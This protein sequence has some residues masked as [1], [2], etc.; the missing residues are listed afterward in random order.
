MRKIFLWISFVMCLGYS[1][2]F[3]TVQSHSAQPDTGSVKDPVNNNTCARAGCHST[4][5]AITASRATVT[6]G[7][8]SGNQVALAGFEYTPGTAYIMNFTVLGNSARPGFQMSALS[9][10]NANAGTFAVTNTTNTSLQTLNTIRYIGHKSANTNNTWSFNW[11]APATNVGNITFYTAVNKSNNSNG[12]SGDSIFH[13]QYVITPA[14]VALTVGAGNDVTV[15]P[16]TGTQ[17]QATASNTSGTT[18]AWSPATGLSCTTCANP[19]ATPATSTTYTVTVTNGGQTASDAVTVNTHTTNAPAITG[20]NTVCP[21]STVTLSSTGFSSYVWST[22][23]DTSSATVNAG[24]TYTLT[25][26]DANGC[27]TTASKTVAQGQAATTSISST[28]PYLCGNNSTVLSAGNF[29]AY[30]WSNNAA[31]ATITA[32]QAGNY[33]VTVTNASGCTGTAAFNLQAFALP[34]ANVSASGPLSFCNGGSVTLTANAG[35]AYTYKWSTGA[36]VQAIS[37]AQSGNYRVTVYNQCDSA[38][39]SIQNVVVNAVPAAQ[40]SPDG[41]LLLCNGASQTLFATPTGAAYVWLKDGAV[42]DGQAADTLPVGT[43]GNYAVIVT[44]GS[45]SDTSQTV[46]ISTAGTGN[47]A[48]EIMATQ[49][50]LCAGETVTLDAG[51]GFSTYTWLP[52]NSATQTLQVTT[53]GTYIVNVSNNNGQCTST[54]AD[55]ITIVT[56]PDVITPVLAYDSTICAGDTIT[57]Q[58]EPSSFSSYVWSNGAS[59]ATISDVTG[60]YSVTVSQV[61]YCGT[62][63]ATI[64][65]AGTALPDASFIINNKLL[66]ANTAGA[67]YQWYRDGSAIPNADGDSYLVNQTGDYSLQVTVNGCSNTSAAQQVI[68]TAI[69]DIEADILI[70]AYPNPVDGVLNILCHVQGNVQLHYSIAGLDGRN[71]GEGKVANLGS[72]VSTIQYDMSAMPQGVYVLQLQSGSFNKSIR[73]LKTQ[74]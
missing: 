38:V 66:T 46:S 52:G 33:T 30:Q 13:Q 68:V 20:A 50:T 21:G 74:P 67:Q 41:P 2:T 7:T 18:Y 22:G 27:S 19:V 34:V 51:T 5:G 3:K 65:A 39:S 63:S 32:S 45:C 17:L 70:G 37:V 57:V 15:C 62:A 44:Q 4:F 26:T 6:I 11:T 73:V 36:T 9:A 8:T 40:L 64:N 28:L 10:A 53:A 60:S 59:T 61:G 55:T 71:A 48:V 25:A 56:G 58:V 47:A 16:N 35:S 42:I 14:Q 72:G 49:T 54:G 29:S 12:S 43:S 24:G 69:Q 23:S 1:L 31:T